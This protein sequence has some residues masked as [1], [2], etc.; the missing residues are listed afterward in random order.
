MAGSSAFVQ[1]RRVDPL[2]VISDA[3][4]E[5][6]LAVAD[7]RFD[8][9]RAGM[10][11]RVAQRLPRNPID[12]IPRIQVQVSP[13]AFYVDGKIGLVRGVRRSRKLLADRCKLFRQ[14][15]LSRRR[16]QVLN[17]V[18]FTY[19]TRME[20]LPNLIATMTSSSW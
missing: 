18:P 16:A 5:E 11:E 8:P 10:P 19:Q 1:N 4:A 12:L 7:F 6:I 9:A 20:N 3:K 17:G 15:P 13:H 2:A 14:M